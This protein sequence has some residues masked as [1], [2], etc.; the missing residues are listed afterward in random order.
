MVCLIVSNSP[1]KVV[2]SP[3]ANHFDLQQEVNNIFLYQSFKAR[4][5][6]GETAMQYYNNKEVTANDKLCFSPLRHHCLRYRTTEN[7][8]HGGSGGC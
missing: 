8:L 4:I 2:N 1:I 6:I 5:L 7:V 3:T